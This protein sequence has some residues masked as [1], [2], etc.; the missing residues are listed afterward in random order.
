MNKKLTSP[1]V[2]RFQAGFSLLELSMVLIVVALIAG[3]VAVGV[4]V[5]RN[6]SYQRM[7]SS[8]VRGWQLAFLSHKTK[9]GVVVG[10]SQTSPT[11]FVNQNTRGTG[12]E[13]CGVPLRTAMLAAGVDMPQGRTQGKES[14]Y[15]Y[16]DSNGNPQELQVCFASIPWLTETTAGVWVDQVRNVMVIKQATPDVARL[17]DS[18][19]DTSRDARFGKVR[20]YPSQAS[21]PGTVPADYSLDNTCVQGSG[22]CGTAL[23]EAQVATMTIYYVM[24]H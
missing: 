7:G 5:Q 22:T 16:L 18:M 3:A 19:V 24:D 1:S 12:T 20:Q 6:A 15:S 17:I 4:D 10:D 21:L 11:G 13:S 9:A 2:R 8:F 14:A 23:D